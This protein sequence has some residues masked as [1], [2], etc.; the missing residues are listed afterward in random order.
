MF[1]AI[2]QILTADQL[3]ERAMKK[4]GK[5][6]ITDRDPHYRYKKTIIA[7]TESIGGY[8]TSALTS[9][10]KEFPSLDNIHPFY[11]ELVQLHLSLDKVKQ[12]LGAVQWASKTIHTIISKQLPTLRNTMNKLVIQQ[13]HREILGRISSVLKQV[14]AHLN[15]LVR[16]QL[17]FKNFPEIQDVP[18]VVIAGYPNVGKSS[19][20]RQLS[21]AKP[22]VAQYPFTTQQIYVGHMVY[23]S[24]HVSHTIQLIDTPGLLDRPF[25]ERNTIEKQ[26]IAALRYLANFIILLIDPSESCGYSLAEQQQLR[27]QILELYP[28]IPIIEIENK[29]DIF[30]SGTSNIRISCKN[31]LGIAEVKNRI[32]TSLVDKD[33]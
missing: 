13:K 11:Q 17:M 6:I 23:K 26:A 18:T 24:K 7:R 3:I 31:Q 14:D 10:V 5:I 8:I 1:T 30:D 12:A 20:L 19:L 29:A 25:T 16:A 21:N 9:Y 2:P 27:N 33:S 28:T 15:L 4:A 22:A 32:I